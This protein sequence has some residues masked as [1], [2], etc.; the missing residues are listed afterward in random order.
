MVAPAPA[1]AAE[2]AGA[3]GDPAAVRVEH[4]SFCYP[5][6]ADPTVRDLSLE[7]P[8]GS[9]C[10]LIGANGAGE[11]V[12]WSRSLFVWTI[13]KAGRG[14]ERKGADAVCG[15]VARRVFVV[16]RGNAL[17][18]PRSLALRS[19]PNRPHAGKTTLLQLLGGKYMVGRK[20]IT[21]LDG[22]PFFDMVRLLGC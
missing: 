18:L 11:S 20:D 1:P 4:L 3:A 9:R 7:L 17:F 12:F 22:A 16:V 5:L 13:E 10:L 8:P 2:V 15:C 6:S 21:I 19:K 14:R